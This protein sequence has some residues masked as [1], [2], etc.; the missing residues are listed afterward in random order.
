MSKQPAYE[1]RE[2]VV[3]DSGGVY[4]MYRHVYEKGDPVDL[5]IVD[6]YRPQDFA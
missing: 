4:I 3:P 5:M 2:V 6:G 1:I